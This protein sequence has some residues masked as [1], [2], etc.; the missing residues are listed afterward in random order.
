MSYR[1]QRSLWAWRSLLRLWQQDTA[2]EA[3]AAISAAL[4]VTL[5]VLVV[6]LA[7]LAVSIPLAP[8]RRP[9]ADI[10][11]TPGTL[12]LGGASLVGGTG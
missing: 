11:L 6:K 1:R 5:A 8:L 4:A 9:L 10:P 12:L 7:V 3:S 2:K